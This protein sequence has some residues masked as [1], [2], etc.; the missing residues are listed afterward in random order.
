MNASHIVQ[1]RDEMVALG[2][3]TMEEWVDRLNPEFLE[4]AMSNVVEELNL[5]LWSHL[6]PQPYPFGPKV[7]GS[8]SGMQALLL[9]LLLQRCD[10]V[11]AA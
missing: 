11:D 5:A 7:C 6:R 4:L 3:Q 10:S 2:I 8:W 1:G 9:L